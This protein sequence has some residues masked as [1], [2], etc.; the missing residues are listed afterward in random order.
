MCRIRVGNAS[1]SIRYDRFHGASFIRTYKYVR[2]NIA[3]GS[4]NF[5]HLHLLYVGGFILKKS[6]TNF[7]VKTL[8][9]QIENVNRIHM[10]FD[11]SLSSALR[12]RDIKI[13]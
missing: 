2:T 8:L 13:T 9:H 7:F 6:Q 12:S 11:F 1:Y 4:D 3:S 10:P 5:T